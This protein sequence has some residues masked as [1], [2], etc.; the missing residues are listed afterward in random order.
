M[1]GKKA[2]A[3]VFFGVKS[4]RMLKNSKMTKKSLKNIF[5]RYFAIKIRPSKNKNSPKQ[6][7]A[8]II[9]LNK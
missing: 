5:S 6:F 3:G 4:M 2:P 8:V 7:T 1:T 9:M